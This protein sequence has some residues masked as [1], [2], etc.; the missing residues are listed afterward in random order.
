M[1]VATLGISVSSNADRATAGLDKLTNSAAKAEAAAN[2]L[3]SATKNAGAAAV[4]AAAGFNTEAKAASAAATAT[5]AAQIAANNNR[6][7][8]SATADAARNSGMQLRMAAMQLS[9]VAQQTQATGHFIQALAIQL[10]DLALGFGPIGIAAGVAAGAVLTYFANVL[11][12]SQESAAALKQQEDAIKAIAEKWA[13]A[14][15]P[16]QEYVENLQRAK[17]VADLNFSGTVVAAKQWDEIRAAVDAFNDDYGRTISLLNTTDD[18]PPKVRALVIAWEDLNDKVKSGKAVM[19][20]FH[21]VRDLATAAAAS[22]GYDDL[23]TFGRGLDALSSKIDGPLGKLRELAPLLGATSGTLR[24]TDPRTWRGVGL[25][26]NPDGAMGGSTSDPDLPMNGPT[27]TSRPLVELDGMP[28]AKNK[29]HRDNAY[30]TATRSITEQTAALHAQT[31]AQAALNPLVNDY[32]YSTAKAKAAQ[33]L[34]SA[35]QRVGT[36]AGKELKDVSQL[37]G[38]D[39]DKLSPAARK[40]AQA[41]LVLAENYGV[42]TE[43]SERFKEKQQEIRKRAEEALNAGKNVISGMID[44]FIEGEKAADIFANALKRIGKALIDDVLNS[45]FKIQ[46]LSGGGGGGSWL[47]SL[48]GGL[49]GGGSQ[50]SIAYGGGI[51]LYADGTASAR[52]GLAMVGEEG[53]E[54]VRFKGGEKVIPN[55]QLRGVNYN[56]GGGQGISVSAPVSIN[57]D[58]TG[59]D[60]AGLARVERQLASLK[61]ELPNQIVSTVQNAQKRRGL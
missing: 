8:L 32:G 54:L 59:A 43:A 23:L 34:L 24:M 45:I 31:A 11:G 61:A 58:A 26:G 3:S 25:I 33:D 48:F 42:A 53:P 52:A 36:A 37:L 17:E 39:F 20:D 60:A 2:G 21:N 16:L 12:Q 18:I 41:M 44:G 19:E 55:H 10:P 30:E 13:G 47:G 50:S 6:A 29:K 14:I 7:A 9:Q 51:G 27:P 1:D 56:R 5:K 49:F 22:R 35:A 40:Q 38:G 15:P 28:W 46:N 57:I 4:S